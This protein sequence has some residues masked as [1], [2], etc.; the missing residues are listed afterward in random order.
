MWKFKWELFKKVTWPKWK[1]NLIYF[2]ACLVLAFLLNHT[3]GQ[4][5]WEKIWLASMG[6]FIFGGI[7]AFFLNDKEK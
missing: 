5:D 4:V 6:L 7:S 3:P 1:R 2:T